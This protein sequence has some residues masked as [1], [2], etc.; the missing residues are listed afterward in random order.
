[1]PD[2]ATMVARMLLESPVP[3]FMAESHANCHSFLANYNK[4]IKY[5]QTIPDLKAPE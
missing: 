4:N 2:K 3:V 1:M 5:H